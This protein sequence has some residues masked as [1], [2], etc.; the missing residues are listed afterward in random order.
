MVKTA[1]WGKSTTASTTGLSDSAFKDWIDPAIAEAGKPWVTFDA[2][3][4]NADLDAAGYKKNGDWR[5]MPD[6]SEMKFAAI[7]PGGYSDWVAVLQI[8]ITNL[9]DVGIQ[10]EL[11]T[12]SPDA[13]STS[14]YTGDFDM[15][16]S[17]G[18]RGA[19]P[20]DFYRGTMSKTTTKPVG[21]TATINFHRYV[22]EDADKLLLDFAGTGDIAEQKTISKQLQQL[23]VDNA[24]VVPL[25]AAPEWGLYTTRRITGFPNEQDQYAPLTNLGNWPTVLIVF[26]H[27]QPAS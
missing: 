20:F 16:L 10:V 8:V 15:S 26:R 19:T 12:T 9:K 2:A 22:N 11:N 5:T 6:G 14:I 18:Q 21:E 23:F 25:Y 13:W 1:L 27:L 24:P 7:V 3:K 17:S 4:A